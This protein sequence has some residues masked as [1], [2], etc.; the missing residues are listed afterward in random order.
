[1]PFSCLFIEMPLDLSSAT[2]NTKDKSSVT[3][4]LPEDANDVSKINTGI[5]FLK[6]IINFI[7]NSINL[8][9][10]IRC[11]KTFEDNDLIHLVMGNSQKFSNR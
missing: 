10:G 6:Q 9:Y 1:M 4:K 8:L 11:H 5:N 7:C 3:E 2:E